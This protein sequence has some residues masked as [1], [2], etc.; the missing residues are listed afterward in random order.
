MGMSLV[1]DLLVP[2]SKIDETRH[3]FPRECS[4]VALTGEKS[5]IMQIIATFDENLGKL[6][7]IVEA[8]EPRVGLTEPKSMDKSQAIEADF[9]SRISGKAK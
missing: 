7:E 3:L 2:R 1:Q 9:E 4:I 6:S 8:D 5:R